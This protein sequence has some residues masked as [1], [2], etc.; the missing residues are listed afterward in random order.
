MI[1][2]VT[3]HAEPQFRQNVLSDGVDAF[4]TKPIVFDFLN[5]LLKNLVRGS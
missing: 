5:D 4:V 1:V 3:A 2:V